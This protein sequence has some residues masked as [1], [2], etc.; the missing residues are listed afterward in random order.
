MCK[1]DRE[2]QGY[3]QQGLGNVGKRHT[4][5]RWDSTPVLHDVL[6]CFCIELKSRTASVSSLFSPFALVLLIFVRSHR[7]S[8]LTISFVGCV[9]SSLACCSAS[10]VS[11]FAIFHS[12]YLLFIPSFL[13]LSLTGGEAHTDADGRFPCKEHVEE[14]YRENGDRNLVQG[15]NHAIVLVL[16][17]GLGLGAEKRR[18]RVSTVQIG[19]QLDTSPLEL[20]SFNGMANPY[21]SPLLFP[22]SADP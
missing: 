8:H 2:D 15:A 21:A 4:V 20:F 6:M 18:K 5:A 9:I 13:L 22:Q 7:C 11:S 19:L 12:L 1:Q 3:C 16:G 17:L 10:R 14:K